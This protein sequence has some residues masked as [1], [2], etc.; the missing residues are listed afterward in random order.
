MVLSG[1]GWDLYR[2]IAN[3]TNWIGNWFEGMEID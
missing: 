3:R 1:A 2:A